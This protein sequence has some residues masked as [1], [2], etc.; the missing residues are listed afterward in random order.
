MTEA[1]KALLRDLIR[2]YG[3]MRFWKNRFSLRESSKNEQEVA[4]A[5]ATSVLLEY[6]RQ[7]GLRQRLHSDLARDQKELI[8]LRVI[9]K[10]TFLDASEKPVDPNT[11]SSQNSELQE[12]PRASTTLNQTV[13]SSATRRKR[14]RRRTKTKKASRA[15]FVNFKPYK[16]D[17][18]PYRRNYDEP[19]N[20]NS[21]A[22]DEVGMVG[23]RKEPKPY[24]RYADEGIGGTREQALQDRN[25]SFSEVRRRYR[26]LD[27]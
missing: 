20:I 19:K 12:Q 8:A 14:G 23:E 16:P 22:D 15:S 26:D 6:E 21:K 9:A 24:L 17:S 7:L 10:L 25:K 5:M 27:D 3:L 2:T 1:D 4:D 13:K 18:D 11:I